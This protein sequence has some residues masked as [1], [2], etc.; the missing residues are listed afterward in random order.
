MSE[1][2]ICVVRKG[3]KLLLKLATRGISIG[4]WNF[5]GGKVEGRETPEECAI[6]EVLEETG[7]RANSITYHG[8][9]DFFFENNPQ[10][11]WSVHIFSTDDFEGT[12]LGSTE[13]GTLK[14]FSASELPEDKMWPADKFWIPMVLAGKKIF[15]E[16]HFNGD[17]TEYISQ[18]IKERSLERQT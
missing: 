15:G 11:N 10:K 9:L 3:D 6:R 7:L 17:G 13:E 2:T 8:K 4:R 18:S 12:Q 1:G 16:V 14:W 5:P